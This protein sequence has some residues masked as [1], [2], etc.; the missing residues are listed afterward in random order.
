MKTIYIFIF[1]LFIFVKGY[2]QGKVISLSPLTEY[3][4]II[5]L[6]A[7]T[8]QKINKRIMCENKRIETCPV[9]YITGYRKITCQVNAR[10]VENGVSFVDKF[11]NSLPKSLVIIS[12]SYNP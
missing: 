6:V 11:K 8:C 9:Y 4:P 3:T 7:D 5:M 12:I 10:Y 1:V 2:S